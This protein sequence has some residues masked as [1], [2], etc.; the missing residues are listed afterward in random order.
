MH[1]MKGEYRPVT[2]LPD[3][4]SQLGDA[5]GSQGARLWHG[6]PAGQKRTRGISF[7]QAGKRVTI[8]QALHVWVPGEAV[9]A[10]SLLSRR[11]R[12]RRRT[13]IGWWSAGSPTAHG[14]VK[15]GEARRGNEGA[16]QGFRKGVRVTGNRRAGRP[17]RLRPPGD[18]TRARAASSCWQADGT[19]RLRRLDDASEAGTRSGSTSVSTTGHAASCATAPTANPTG[20]VPAFLAR[21]AGTTGAGWAAFDAGRQATGSRDCTRPASARLT[22]GDVALE[23]NAL[24]FP[25]L[26]HSGTDQSKAVATAIESCRTA[27]PRAPS[28]VR[29]LLHERLAWAHA[30]AG[31]ARET[32]AALHAAEE[33][34]KRGQQRPG[35]GLGRLGRLRRSRDDRRAGAGRNCVVHCARSPV[36]NPSWLDSATHTRQGQGAVHVLAGESLS[37]S[38]EVETAAASACRVL[39]LSVGVASVRPR[40]RLAPTLSALTR[41]RGLPEVEE[42][43]E[44]AQ[45]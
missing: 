34:L 35:A 2:A 8:A 12:D 21:R 20:N 19:A 28:G 13:R 14:E 30:V 36:L 37:G 31:H 17:D 43:L 44:R 15:Q 23:G 27:G 42:L 11:L 38:G 3:E 9:A 22:A 25:R 29:A 24:A 4:T 16:T 10:P 33:A 5:R 40:Q 6:V 1:R 41:H 7:T 32:E 39:E 45:A 18:P 26:P